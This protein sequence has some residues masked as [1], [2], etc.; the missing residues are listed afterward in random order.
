MY[1]QLHSFY[2]VIC[3]LI[4][5]FGTNPLLTHDLQVF[6]SSLWLVY[7]LTEGHTTEKLLKDILQQN[8]G[9]NKEKKYVDTEKGVV[10]DPKK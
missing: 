5:L 1:L 6:S 7:F 3:I 9:W 2:L 8:E 10:T 4:I